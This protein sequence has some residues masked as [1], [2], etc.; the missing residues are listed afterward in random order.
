MSAKPS[1]TTRF[2][3]RRTSAAR[4]STSLGSAVPNLRAARGMRL[5]NNPIRDADF[6]PHS[7]DLWSKLRRAY[8]GPRLTLN[9]ALLLLFL[10]PY[11]RRDNSAGSASTAP[12]TVSLR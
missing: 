1:S 4:S 7:D 11:V 9:L 3:R 8:T 2:V 5:S 6:Q 10:T 12:K